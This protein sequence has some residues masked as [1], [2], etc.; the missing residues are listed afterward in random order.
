MLPLCRMV[1]SLLQKDQIKKIG[2][3]LF[4]RDISLEL[5][6]IE[7]LNQDKIEFVYISEFVHEKNKEIAKEYSFYN[8]KNTEM[9]NN[10][11]LIKKMHLDLV[12]FNLKI[13]DTFFLDLRDRISNF[14]PDVIIRDSCAIYGKKLADY[15]N[16]QCLG[17]TTMFGF[18]EEQLI[19]NAEFGLKLLLGELANRV[20]EKD[21]E[22][23]YKEL[24]LEVQ[25]LLE[26][27]GYRIPVNYMNDG[28]EEK[29]LIFAPRWNITSSVK[30]SK[31][32]K[33][34]Y[35]KPL[36]FKSNENVSD[37]KNRLL[38]VCGENDMFPRWV[39]EDSINDLSKKYEDVFVGFK[40]YDHPNIKLNNVPS[41]VKISRW[42]NQQ[43]LLREAKLFITHGGFNSVMES[44]DNLVPMIVIPTHHDQYINSIF[45]EMNQLGKSLP[46]KKE[47][48]FELETVEKKIMEDYP[49]ENLRKMKKKIN[50]LPEL[51]IGMEW[52]LQNEAI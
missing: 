45:V 41:N 8:G 19:D 32:K 38:I 49:L 50:D 46:Y 9:I 17:Y 1:I 28:G 34:K 4:E 3:C 7:R 21:R 12:E 16:S 23:L 43:D 20:P 33:Y 14:K 22:I 29:N 15:V 44:I 40:L 26:L 25:R 42:I 47:D 18:P 13:S 48:D 31:T 51:E 11:N 27:Y 5:K 2:I 24:S 52:L 35:C 6:E 36:S 10:T 39:Y 30:E 37:K